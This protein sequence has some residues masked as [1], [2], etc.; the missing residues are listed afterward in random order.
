MN[1][2]VVDDAIFVRKILRSMITSLGHDVCCEVDNGIDALERYKISKP[3]M[4]FMDINMGE[5]DGLEALR[6]I[7]EYDANAM[8]VICTVHNTSN[9]VQEAIGLGAI[10]YITKPIEKER[11]QKCFDKVERMLNPQ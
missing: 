5:M 11:L 2:L 9:K 6:K 1:I 10:D 4:V 8:I 7:K 3:D